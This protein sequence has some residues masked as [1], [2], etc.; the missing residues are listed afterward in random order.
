MAGNILHA[1]NTKRRYGRKL[2]LN[3]CVL[4]VPFLLISSSANGKIFYFT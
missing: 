4:T 3:N 1:Y 2:S